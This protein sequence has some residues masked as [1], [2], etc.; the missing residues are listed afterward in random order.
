MHYYYGYCEDDDDV[1]VHRYY[2]SRFSDRREPDGSVFSRVSEQRIREANDAGRPSVYAVATEDEVLCHLEQ[3]PTI[4]QLTW[5]QTD[6]EWKDW[7]MPVQVNEEG[8]PTRKLHFFRF[9]LNTPF[10]CTKLYG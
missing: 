7:F 5:L 3:D 4:C 8:D 9:L 6:L 2:L 10:C 1:A